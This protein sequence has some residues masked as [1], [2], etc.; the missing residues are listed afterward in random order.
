MTA[1]NSTAVTRYARDEKPDLNAN[2]SASAKPRNAAFEARVR[3][4]QAGA[5]HRAAIREF[6]ARHHADEQARIGALLS[7]VIAVLAEG[8]EAKDRSIGAR[9]ACW[10]CHRRICRCCGVQAARRAA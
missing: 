3:Q 10:R 6:R 5:D 2:R 1:K 8:L 4:L 7:E 9:P